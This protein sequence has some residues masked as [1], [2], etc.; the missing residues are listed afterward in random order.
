M[1]WDAII[2]KYG[3]FIDSCASGGGRNDPEFFDPELDEGFASIACQEASSK[4]TNTICLKGLDPEKQYHI[5]DFEGLVDVTAQ[6]AD[7]MEHWYA[8]QHYTGHAEG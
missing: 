2:E 6:G 1:R 8:H 5:T 7:L 4:L 3:I